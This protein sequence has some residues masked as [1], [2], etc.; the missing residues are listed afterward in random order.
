MT[1]HL[2][3]IKTPTT[4]F[5]LLYHLPSFKDITYYKSISDALLSLKCFWIMS[6][7]GSLQNFLMLKNA[8]VKFSTV[9]AIAFFSS[10]FFFPFPWN[11][12]CH[13]CSLWAMLSTAD[14]LNISGLPLWKIL[15]RWVKAIRL[16]PLGSVPGKIWAA[17]SGTEFGDEGITADGF[18]GL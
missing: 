16:W 7:F 17:T 14:S 4:L 5:C 3:C 18:L 12:F 6:L 15:S 9:F 1:N 10:L 11:R 2:Q 13:H 8:H